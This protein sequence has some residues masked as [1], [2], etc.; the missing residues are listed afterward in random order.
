MVAQHLCAT[1][2]ELALSV[3]V[4]EAGMR[5][6]SLFSSSS[7][8]EEEGGATFDELAALCRLRSAP[9]SSSCSSS[10]FS[11]SSS[12]WPRLSRAIER[13]RRGNGTGSSFA[14]ELLEALA[15]TFDGEAARKREDARRAT[16][17]VA[18][19]A[20]VD[21]ENGDSLSAAL[22]LRQLE[23]ARE[24]AARSRGRE[25]RWKEAAFAAEAAL[26]EALEAA[27]SA[28]VGARAARGG[29]RDDEE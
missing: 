10:S 28:G 3:F 25:L 13:N 26:D 20:A 24:Q 17:P 16:T 18:A 23:E 9:S 5:A 8:L 4:P 14:K 27:A 2:R 6:E 11:S 19:P 15:S 21:N 29:G 1:G 7:G 22:L 12:A